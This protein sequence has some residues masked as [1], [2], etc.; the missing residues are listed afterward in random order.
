MLNMENF[1]EFLESSTIHGLSYVSTTRRFVKI[2]WILVVTLGFTF[3]G[4]LIFQS[5]DTWAESPVKTTIETL[6][7]TEITFPKVTVCPPKNTYTNLNFDILMTENMTLD[8]ENRDKLTTYAA[9]LLQDYLFDAVM[10]NLSKLEDDDRYYN[11]YNGYTQISLPHPD[12]WTYA[13]LLYQVDTYAKSGSVSTQHF[14]D[15]FDGAKVETNINYDIQIGVPNGDNIFSNRN[16]T[17]HVQ[18]EK[19]SI[20]ESGSDRLLFNYAEYNPDIK[21][22]K[23]IY[24]PPPKY[25]PT[26]QVIRRVLAEDVG[27]MNMKL[28][29][30]FNITW[31]YTGT[32]VVEEEA[33]F[34]K[35]TE[36]KAFVRNIYFQTNFFPLI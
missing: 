26:A 28:M 12:S 29:P 23:K 14:G 31:F 34:Q 18:I 22:I 16:I 1:R 13:D 7:I 19:V 10:T 35:N 6:P 20:K 15:M 36:T 5:F 17:L 4:Y 8:Q 27:K 11:W 21:N 3:A 32:G 2:S 24:N 9:D 30:G 25:G 33:Y